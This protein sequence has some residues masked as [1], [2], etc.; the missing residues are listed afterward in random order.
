[1]TGPL[2]RVFDLAPLK[3]RVIAGLGEDVFLAPP[4]EWAVRDQSWGTDPNPFPDLGF[5]NV[6]TGVA[7]PAPD[8]SGGTLSGNQTMTAG[9][10]IQGK[11]INGN[12][13]MA[14]DCQL[15]DCIVNG[16]IGFVS[17]TLNALIENNKIYGAASG[18][19]GGHVI[20]TGNVGAAVT[21]VTIRYNDIDVS[22]AANY[23]G[24]SIGPRRY[25]AEKNYMKGTADGFGWWPATANGLV[26]ILARGNYLDTLKFTKPEPF[27]NMRPEGTHNDSNQP[28]SGN[29]G[30]CYQNVMVAML[31]GEV[32]EAP[33][34]DG[35]KA[36]ANAGLMLNN[37]GGLGYLTNAGFWANRIKGGGVAINA[38]PMGANNTG[39]YMGMNLVD[40]TDLHLGGGG[41]SILHQS[42]N[43]AGINWG[44]G[45][46][47]NWVATVDGAKWTKTGTLAPKR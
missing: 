1:M 5:K 37:A 43:P 38:D 24:D 27:G 26:H 18:R 30:D 11:T 41:W 16:H 20:D 25:T 42:G 40:G 45:D 15:L 28:Q 44:S 13:T 36:W 33:T 47:R 3:W 6:G 10:V 9:Q 31:E 32:S 23:Y 29:G 2:V 46:Y 34:Y 39:L 7:R 35:T 12:V 17:N 22:A 8:G 4:W 21:A 19:N 14:S